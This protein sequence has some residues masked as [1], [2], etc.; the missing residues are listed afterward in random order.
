MR[1]LLNQAR[2][3]GSCVVVCVYEHRRVA[4]TR[5]YSCPLTNGARE[6]GFTAFISRIIDARSSRDGE[7]LMARYPADLGSYQ[8]CTARKRTTPASTATTAWLFRFQRAHQTC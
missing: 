1:S 2:L 6:P 4:Y 5:L 7:A 3:S 8:I